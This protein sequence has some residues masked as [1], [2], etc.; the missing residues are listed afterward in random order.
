MNAWLGS[1]EITALSD[2]MNWPTTE[3]APIW[4][5]FR[6][7]A[8]AAPIQRWTEQEWPFESRLPKWAKPSYSARVHVDEQSGRVAVVSPDYREITGIQQSLS[9]LSPSLLRVDYAADGQSAIIRR[10]GR[11]SASWR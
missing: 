4:R 5:R 6:S 10:M 1:N 8:L 2:D 7:E 9:S 11:G 3:A